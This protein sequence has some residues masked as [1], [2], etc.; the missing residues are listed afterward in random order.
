MP[1]QVANGVETTEGAALMLGEL[2][3]GAA[4]DG[5][6]MHLF[7]SSFAPT[8]ASNAAAFAEAEADFTGYAPAALTYSGQGIDASGTPTAITDRVFFQA[9]DGVTPNTIGGCWIEYDSMATPPVDTSL[10]YYIF[11]TPVPMVSAGAF[12]GVV[13]GVQLPQ[14]D[15]YAIVDY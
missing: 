9:T 6:K 15:G 3:A 4:W 14:S 8:P 11:P 10:E 13:V 2:L 12:C 1:Q 7:Q 5:A